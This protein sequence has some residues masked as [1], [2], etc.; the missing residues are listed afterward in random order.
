MSDEW[1]KMKAKFPDAVVFCK[2]GDEYVCYGQ[3]A[4]TVAR[5]INVPVIGDVNM[6]FVSLRSILKTF[7]ARSFGQGNN[8]LLYHGTTEA[9]KGTVPGRH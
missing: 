8:R 2:E 9:S 6:L 1:K 7:S 5:I 4:T 3:D